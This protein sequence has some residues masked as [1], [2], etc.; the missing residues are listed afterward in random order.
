[1]KVVYKLIYL[2]ILIFFVSIVNISSCQI[3]SWTQKDFNQKASDFFLDSAPLQQLSYLDEFDRCVLT[4]IVQHQLNDLNDIDMLVIGEDVFF[5]SYT[6]AYLQ[7][8]FAF[9]YNKPT[10]QFFFLSLFDFYRILYEEEVFDLGGNLI[11]PREAIQL[12]SDS[13]NDFLCSIKSNGF[14]DTRKLERILWQTLSSVIPING[15]ENVPTEV[16]LRQLLSDVANGSL[17][18][19]AYDEI[20][21]LTTDD[22]KIKIMPIFSSG[23]LI[24]KTN[25]TCDGTSVPLKLYFV[26]NNRGFILSHSQP[27]SSSRYQDCVRSTSH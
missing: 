27:R 5:K 2:P 11:R 7:R 14:S 16:F 18:K 22:S 23:Y 8:S 12:D 4:H 26:P 13:F 20:I 19:S 21:R 17:Q 3:K 6:S 25:V 1:M 15:L 24:V 10:Q 9:G